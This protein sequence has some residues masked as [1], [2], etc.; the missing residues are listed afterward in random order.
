[1]FIASERRQKIS[2][3]MHICLFTLGAHIMCLEF[4]MHCDSNK[5]TP[6]IHLL[7]FLFQDIL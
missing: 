4:N 5:V 7:Y 6:G 2:N 1:M 3:Y